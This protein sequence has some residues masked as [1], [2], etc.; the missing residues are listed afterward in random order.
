VTRSSWFANPSNVLH[1][2]QATKNLV[3]IHH[4]ATD[5]NFFLEFH[6]YSFLV[7]DQAMR[8]LLLKGRCHRGLYPLP[9]SFARQVFGVSRPSFH[10]W[11]SHLGHPTMVIVQK[12]ISLFNLPCH[13]ESNKES[14]CDVCQQAKSH[15][16]PYSKPSSLSSH[17]LELIHSYVWSPAPK[18]VHRFKYYV[19]FVD[20]FSKF[21]CIY[22]IKH[23]YEV[24]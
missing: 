20:D 19:S 3:S 12:V 14:V 11:H 2:P 1:V 15:Q 8:K 17:P 24:F 7:K 22:L 6:P 13:N 18:S 16:L 5:N 9:S 4:L 21:T 10:K 23:K